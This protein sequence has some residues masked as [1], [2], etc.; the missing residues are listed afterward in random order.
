MAKKINITI[1]FNTLEAIANVVCQIKMIALCF[2]FFSISQFWK[3]E[4]LAVQ[5]EKYS[6]MLPFPLMETKE[7]KLCKHNFC[8]HKLRNT[9]QKPK[10]QQSGDFTEFVRNLR[11]QGS[12]QVFQK[13]V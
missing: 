3:Q 11:W 2:V 9:L 8:V 7:F 4:N 13:S 5:K 12:G 1:F 6:S 10:V